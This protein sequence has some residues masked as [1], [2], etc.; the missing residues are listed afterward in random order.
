MSLFVTCRDSLEPD[1]RVSAPRVVFRSGRRG[2]GG[3]GEGVQGGNRGLV[4]ESL[5]PCLSSRPVQKWMKKVSLSG[6][7]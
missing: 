3:A 4:G 6:L 2:E 7:M 1:P 5:T